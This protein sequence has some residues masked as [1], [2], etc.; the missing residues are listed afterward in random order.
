MKPSRRI[1]SSTTRLIV[2]ALIFTSLTSI[3]CAEEEPEVANCDKFLAAYQE[4]LDASSVYAFDKSESICLSF[5]ESI[6]NLQE[7]LNTTTCSF[8]QS[9]LGELDEA[10]NELD[11]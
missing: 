3:S 1:I 7:E 9:I 10:Y 6:E 2:S 11:C 8:D 5:K 4:F